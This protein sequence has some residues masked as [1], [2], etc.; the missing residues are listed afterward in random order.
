MYTDHLLARFNMIQ[1]QI[2]PWD[3]LDDR[4]LKV[5]AELE[6]E[7][8]VPGGYRG[9]TYA[10]IEIPLGRGQSML[11][12]KVVGRLLQALAI[13]PDDKILEVG[14]G[15]GYVSA[16]LSLLGGRVVS[17][18]IEPELADAARERLQSLDLDRIEVIEADA[19]AGPAPGSPFDVIAITG[20]APSE[21]A[22]G[23]L[24]DQLA[25]GGR[26]FCIIGE[27]PV[28]EARLITRVGARELRRETLFETCVPELTN[29][30]EPEG[31]VF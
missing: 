12:P 1:Q 20:S 19:L 3:V 14:T 5:M 15:T 25:I 6:R 26:L 22:L 2:R 10:D 28:M 24:E 13:R 17:L 23:V 16:C 11:A 29:V 8:F 21:D 7:P 30:P 9:L 31:F 18:E 4:V 27:P